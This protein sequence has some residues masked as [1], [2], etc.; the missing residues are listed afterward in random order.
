MTA[1]LAAALLA[2]IPAESLPDIAAK[3]QPGDTAE[4]VKGKTDGL[5]EPKLT[6]AWCNS[7]SRCIPKESDINAT[8]MSAH[9]HVEA[10]GGTHA[11][12]VHFCRG[13]DEWKVGSVYVLVHAKPGAWGTSKRPKPLYENMSL[14]DSRPCFSGR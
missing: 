2:A 3:I 13:G 1:L 8:K 10:P 14:D 4:A 5:G 9:W 12:V 6:Y 7:P 11:L